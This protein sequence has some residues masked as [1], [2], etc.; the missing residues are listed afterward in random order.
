M[1]FKD[2]DRLSKLLS[3]DDFIGD[4]G[5]YFLDLSIGTI[6]EQRKKIPNIGKKY[7]RVSMTL[8]C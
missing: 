4:S 5:V 6:R 3:E 8:N 7:V 1:S 2:E